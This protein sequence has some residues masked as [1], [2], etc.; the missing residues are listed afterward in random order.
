MKEIFDL[1]KT[2][3][4]NYY[5]ALAKGNKPVSYLS[6]MAPQEV[7]RT[8]DFE[9]FLPENH[10]AYLG[11]KRKAEFF[12]KNS[13]QAGF[14][15]D[16]CS[17]LL[18]DI[19]ANLQKICGFEEYGLKNF[20]QPSIFCYSTNQC[21]EI[22]EWF[23]FLG[24]LYNVPVL[25]IPSLKNYNGE[26]E[27]L[28]FYEK[29]I[30][31]LIKN[32]EDFTGKKLDIKKLKEFLK[33]T[34]ETSFYFNEILNLNKNNGFKFSFLDHLFLMSPMVLGRGKYETLE[35]YKKIYRLSEK[36]KDKE[37]K[38]RLWWE[39]MPVWG[40]LRY[41]KEKFEDLK[42]GIVG[43]TYASSWVFSFKSVNP[44]KALSEI[45]Y[46]NLFITWSEEKKMDWL[47]KKK[48]EF[49]IDGFIFMEA[50]TCRANT[51]TYYGMPEKIY[52][53]T[54]TPYLILSSDMVDLRHFSEAETNL[55]LE[56][57]LETIEKR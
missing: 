34:K 49:K 54:G 41:F 3:L 51:N 12:I 13:I 16:I 30:L 50:K 21:Y 31:N 47:I 4:K 20:P 44:V 42:I 28:N 7:F 25:F 19:G 8:F 43:S 38:Y 11:A 55:K 10:A 5:E 57:F 53:K 17:Y 18:T 26:K 1:L 29:N 37:I 45:Y 14:S 35:F 15:P 9:V 33:I 32:L 48:E 40:K 22:G 39:G 46:K 36:E 52:K 27:F 23:K 6:A 2:I 56:A 24:K